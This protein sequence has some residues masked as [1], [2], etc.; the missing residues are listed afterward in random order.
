MHILIYFYLRTKKLRAFVPN[1]HPSIS[2]IWGPSKFTII[3]FPS[4]FQSIGKIRLRR[5]CPYRFNIQSEKL[6]T[7]A[8]EVHTI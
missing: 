4:S 3:F 6:R 7:A 5:I 2:E 8:K 1:S